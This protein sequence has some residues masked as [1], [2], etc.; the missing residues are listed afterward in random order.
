MDDYIPWLVLIRAPMIGPVQQQKLLNIYETPSGL[1]SATETELEEIGLRQDTIRFIKDPDNK[2]LD[3]DIA[4]LKDSNRH[5]IS[6]HDCRYPAFLKEITD[7]PIGLFVEGD[8]E[9]LRTK[10]IGVV[11]SRNPTSGGRQ[12]A[13]YFAEQLVKHG[14]TITSGLA[15]GID[16]CAH[17]GALEAGG[18]TI[19]VLGNGLDK[20]YPA[21][22]NNIAEKIKINGVLVSEFPPGTPPLPVHFPRRNRIIS[23]MSLGVL[24]IEAA[25]RS[26]SLITARYAMEQGREVFAIPGSIKNPLSKGCHYLIKQGAKL[27]ETLEDIFEELNFPYQVHKNIFSGHENHLSKTDELDEKYKQLM[28]NISYDPVSVDKLIELTGLTADTVSS[29]LLILEV[30]GAI[31][32]SGGLYTR[33]N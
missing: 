29:M 22:H 2:I 14:L 28:E 32:S 30:Q 16:Y 17:S 24:V 8:P 26:G 19:A 1:L 15:L 25:Q 33:I 9:I 13:Q 5:F 6:I 11:G 18:N 12:T 27:V 10:Q 31:S 21:R 3:K 7:Y 4:W 20:I 23:G